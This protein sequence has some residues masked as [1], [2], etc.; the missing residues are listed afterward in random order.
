VNTTR[1]DRVQAALLLAPVLVCAWPFEGSLLVHDVAPQATGIGFVALALLPSAFLLVVRKAPPS[2]RALWFLLV[3]LLVAGFWVSVD[4]STDTFEGSR[5]LMHWVVALHCA[6]AG[7]SLG[8]EGRAWFVRGL[9]ATSIAYVSFALSDGDGA[10]TG[11][12]G[13]TGS[14]SEVGLAGAV[15]GAAIAVFS[16]GFQRVFGVA[17]LCLF[18]AYTA[19]VPVLAGSLGCAIGVGALLLVALRR[20]RGAVPVAGL[21]LVLAVVA[22]VI[23]LAGRSRANDVSATSPPPAIPSATGGVGVRLLVW[24]GSL[25]MLAEHPLLGVG[26]G[27][28]A[29]RFPEH[30]LQEEIE[31]TTY[32]RRRAEETEVEHPH[33]DWLAPWLEGGLVSGVPWTI[34]LVCALL[35]ARKKLLSADPVDIAVAAS[36]VAL[37]ANAFVRAPLLANPASSPLAFALFGIVLARAQDP[38]R[39]FARRA[40]V[41]A[42]TLLLAAVSVRAVAFVRHGRALQDVAR[43]DASVDEVRTANAAALD[44]CPD[45]VLALTTSARLSEGRDEAS[46]IVLAEW[47]KVTEHRPM[48]IE[49]LLTIG[50]LLAS[51]EPAIAAAAFERVLRLDPTHP[52]AIQNLGTLALNAGRVNAGLAYFDALPAHR[53]PSQEWLE[54]LAALLALRGVDDASDALFLRLDP[55][56]ANAG[57]EQ[58][59]AFSKAAELDARDKL[60]VEAWKERAQLRWARRHAADGRF[61]DAVR[62]YRQ[63]LRISEIHGIDPRRTRLETSAA[64]RLAGRADEAAEIAFGIEATPEDLAAVPE[65][66]RAPLHEAAKEARK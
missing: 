22:L 45:S 10:F 34:F 12:L 1:A 9:I 30:R 2:M 40:I 16:R 37:L 39:V 53:A 58:C 25:A 11:A 63:A 28:F 55:S 49:A 20:A 35:A 52:V 13:N 17:A 66:A 51:R 60:V 61:A 5:V 46:P 56:T 32:G 8:T 50:R 65:W 38:A 15:G 48:R 6:L 18:L 41:V 7:A 27:Q 31:R 29:A 64:L 23:P 26:A 24:R 3:P 44:A 54:R 57:A 59:L 14:I 21:C 42:S 19:R 62:S 47:T 4:D 36:A 43:T 33:N